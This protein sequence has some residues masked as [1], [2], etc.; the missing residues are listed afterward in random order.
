MV[1][2]FIGGIYL[3]SKLN[4]F[5]SLFSDVAMNNGL[6]EKIIGP[7]NPLWKIITN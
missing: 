2:G 6:V 3:G 4:I 5:G 1:G 7:V